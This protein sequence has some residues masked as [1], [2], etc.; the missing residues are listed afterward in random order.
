MFLE[1]MDNIMAGFHVVRGSKKSLP[2]SGFDTLFSHSLPLSE[3]QQ[4]LAFY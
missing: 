4:V 1:G 3:A 2:L